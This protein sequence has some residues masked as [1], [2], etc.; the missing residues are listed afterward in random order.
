MLAFDKAGTNVLRLPVL[1]PAL[2]SPSPPLLL[3]SCCDYTQPKPNENAD[4]S[5]PAAAAVAAAARLAR[6]LDNYHRAQTSDTG[7]NSS[8]NDAVPKSIHDDG[9]GDR[10]RGGAHER[11]GQGEEAD[12]D[13]VESDAEMSSEKRDTAA[14]AATAALSACGEEDE[15]KVAAFARQLQTGGGETEFLKETG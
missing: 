2:L 11:D 15:A 6:S 10:R 4:E 8:N 3:R 5:A 12:G 9:G 14:A 13:D 7:G 1:Q